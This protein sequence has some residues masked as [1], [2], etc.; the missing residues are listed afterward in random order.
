M[1]PK[2]GCKWKGI[3]L[4]EKNHE[5]EGINYASLLQRIEQMEEDLSE[6][7]SENLSLEESFNAFEDIVVNS[8]VTA[9]FSLRQI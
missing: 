2:L 9:R 6:M 1:S 5:H 4:N 7:E 3:R 8:N